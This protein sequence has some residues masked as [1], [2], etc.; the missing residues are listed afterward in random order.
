ML[1]DTSMA[2]TMLRRVRAD[3]NSAIMGCAILMSATTLGFFLLMAGNKVSILRVGAMLD[4]DI[5]WIS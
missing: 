3:F 2:K 1:P 4:M 5:S